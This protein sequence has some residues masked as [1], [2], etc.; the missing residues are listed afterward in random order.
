ML[1][2]DRIY[3]SEGVDPTKNNKRR[4]CII[5]HYCFFNH[6][7]EFQYSVW[8]GCHD[9]SI[10]CL[11]ISNIAVTTFENVDYCCMMCNITKS[12]AI[13]LLEISVLENLVYI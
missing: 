12:E 8:N 2:Y 11:N 10:L 6:G 5:C 4:E 9:L 3:I 7:F 13:N 1:H